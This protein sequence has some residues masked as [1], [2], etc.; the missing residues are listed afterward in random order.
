MLQKIILAAAG[1]ALVA[2]PAS[3]RDYR[4]D[5][6]RYDRDNGGALVGALLGA[7]AGA[8][9]VNSVDRPTYGYDYPAYAYGPPVYADPYPAYGY[10]YPAY[11]YSYPAPT[12]TFNYGYGYSP[13]GYGRR[14]RGW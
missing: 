3:A 9:I 11:G 4:W 8:A 5:H 13:R 1:T 2:A 10:G 6:H 14:Y 7:V 12:V